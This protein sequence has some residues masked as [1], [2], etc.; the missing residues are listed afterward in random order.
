MS[1]W[2]IYFSVIYITKLLILPTAIFSENGSTQIKQTYRFSA[3]PDN[4]SYKIEINDL[5]G[6]FIISG[7]E[8]SGALIN[9][10]KVLFG[11]EKKDIPKMHKKANAIVTHIENENIIK[12]TAPT[13]EKDTQFIENTI[14]LN[15]PKHINLDFNIPGGDITLKTINGKTTLNT[16]GGDIL[17]DDFKGDIQTQTN[18]GNIT[19]QNS[20]GSLRMHTFG[21]NLEIENF[22]GETYS[23]TIGG[24]ISLNNINGNINCQTS[25]GSI[26]LTK[27]NSKKTL[28]RASG[29]DIK[30][31]NLIGDITMKSFGGDI[32]V[33]K[34]SNKSD[35]YC[36]GGQI[37]VEESNGTLICKSERGN[38]IINNT[39]GIIDAITSSGNINLDLN[40]DSTIKN[41]SVSLETHSGSITANIPKEFPANIENIVYQTT[42]PKVIN[43]EIVLKISIDN[44]KVIGTRTIAGGTIP[45]QLKAHHGSITIKDN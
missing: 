39:T 41:N 42:S 9:I 31:E 28:V 25:G 33:N 15:L 3:L 2:K 37:T 19:I 4:G 30:S 6:N 16:L 5:S 27:I 43:S 32:Q 40:Y 36:S 38:I 21:G 18:G 7:H 10:N 26:Y 29:G 13:K 12:I 14:E 22:N 45:F 23:S 8:G 44:D 24:N 17:I 11:I 1:V 35:I 20:K 34:I